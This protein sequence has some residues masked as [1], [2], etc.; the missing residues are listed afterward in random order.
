MVKI[1]RTLFES[2]YLNVD[3]LIPMFVLIS[4]FK[5]FLNAKKVFFPFIRQL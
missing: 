4:S 2:R 5:I 1:P 3:V